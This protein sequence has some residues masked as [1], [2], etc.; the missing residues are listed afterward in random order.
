MEGPWLTGYH[1][2]L[3]CTANATCGPSIPAF[4]GFLQ[5]QC[6]KTMYENKVHTYSTSYS[7]P[8]HPL[9]SWALHVVIIDVLHGITALPVEN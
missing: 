4:F 9:H 7:T 3:V 2:I 1:G 8:S 6:T 5:K